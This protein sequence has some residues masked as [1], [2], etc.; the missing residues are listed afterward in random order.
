MFQL[1]KN[2]FLLFPDEE[3][4]ITPNRISHVKTNKNIINTTT[5]TKP[6]TNEIN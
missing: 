2:I 5:D 3:S 1:H 4:L 6:A